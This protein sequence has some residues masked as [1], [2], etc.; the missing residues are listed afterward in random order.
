LNHLKD[1]LNVF[2]PLLLLLSS[3]IACVDLYKRAPTNRR[4]SKRKRDIEITQD[5]QVDEERARRKG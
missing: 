1:L 5:H 4:V 3:A 2:L